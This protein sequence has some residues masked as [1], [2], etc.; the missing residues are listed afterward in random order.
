VS[1]TCLV[2]EDEPAVRR[3]VSIVLEEL[4]C[5]VLT[6]PDAE[7]ALEL[8]ATA[9]PDLVLADVRLPGMDGIELAR[10]LKRAPHLARVPV[11][12]M[13]ACGEP[14]HHDGDGF[15]PKPFDLEQLTDFLARYLGR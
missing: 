6:A 14:P 11:L 15:L 5:R 2:V 4:G 3:L 8:L 10:R 9:R 13:S 1:I 7:A 12:L